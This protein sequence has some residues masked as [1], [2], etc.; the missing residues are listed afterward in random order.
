MNDEH[1]NFALDEL[2]KSGLSIRGRE[3][4]DGLF[5]DRSLFT[6]DKLRLL[7]EQ[8]R[9]YGI[10]LFQDQA[11]FDP[12]EKVK[13]VDL[14]QREKEVL[15]KVPVNSWVG[16]IDLGTSKPVLTK[17]CD[18]KLIVKKAILNPSGDPRKGFV[19]QRKNK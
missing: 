4:I 10:Y 5:E 16:Q 12:N 8:G 9:K 19:Y 2:V 1:L 14:T 13:M 15:D 17:L 6:I 18:A 7:F 3:L 11:R